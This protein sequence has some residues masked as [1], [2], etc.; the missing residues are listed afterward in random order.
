MSDYHS[1]INVGNI[2][3]VA[4]QRVI[5]AIVGC[6]NTKTEDELREYVHGHNLE[7]LWS[8]GVL[9][10]LDAV[11]SL[12]PDDV[13][14]AGRGEWVHRGCGLFECDRCGEKVLTHVYTSEEASERFGFC[15]G[16]GARMRG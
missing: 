10:A 14:P 9:D 13:V 16:C 11:K 1:D 8:G 15:P 7:S 3:Y 2:G 6:T 12:Y 4:K 5:N